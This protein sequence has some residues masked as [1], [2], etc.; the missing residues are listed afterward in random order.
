[1]HDLYVHMF[2]HGWIHVHVYSFLVV[3]IMSLYEF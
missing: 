3:K 2:I 1:M